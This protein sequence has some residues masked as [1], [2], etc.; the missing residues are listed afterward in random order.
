MPGMG[1]EGFV[2]AG[3][4]AVRSGNVLR[5]AA[6]QPCYASLI[7]CG[8]E[9]P[10][11]SQVREA[12]VGQQDAGDGL[13]FVRAGATA[14]GNQTTRGALSFDLAFLAGQKIES[15]RVCAY[16]SASEAAEGTPNY[17]G[18]GYSTNGSVFVPPTQDFMAFWY[19]SFGHF[20]QQ[21]EGSPFRGTF[22]W[23]DLRRSQWCSLDLTDLVRS[24]GAGGATLTTYLMHLREYCNASGDDPNTQL[25]WLPQ[26]T[27]AA[28]DNAIYFNEDE[29][30]LEV[31]LGE[32][33]KRLDYASL[34]ACPRAAGRFASSARLDA[35]AGITSRLRG[36]LAQL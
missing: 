1:E 9:P 13:P 14:L 5:L 34:A 16:W 33:R 36:H 12:G 7:S 8:E 11:W 29:P 23:D 21:D 32:G 4:L 30:Y 25:P 24:I 10:D 22:S 20:F 27:W 3:P 31:V 35:S 19:S 17:C 15:G 2:A 6:W 26:G 28:E 18:V